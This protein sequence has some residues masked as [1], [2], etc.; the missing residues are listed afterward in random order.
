MAFKGRDPL[1]SEFVLNNNIEQI[2]TFSFSSY[3]ISYQNKKYI[4][5]KKKILQITGII[6]PLAQDFFFNFSTSYI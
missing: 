4:T 3:S 2:K 1:R 6:N 5:M